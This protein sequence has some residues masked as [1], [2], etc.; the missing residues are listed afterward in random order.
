MSYIQNLPCESLQRIFELAARSGSAED[1]AKAGVIS[2][3][4]L[5]QVNRLF[6]TICLNTPSLWSTVSNRQP[7]HVLRL[8]IERSKAHPLCV[9]FLLYLKDEY[10]VFLKTLKRHAS[11]WGEFYF[12]SDMQYDTF[13]LLYHELRVIRRDLDLPQL[14]KLT[15]IYPRPNHLSRMDYPIEV[16]H[17]VHTYRPEHAS[18]QFY[19]SW[20]TPNLLSVSASNVFP[21]HTEGA[22]LESYA[23]QLTGSTR[24]WNC[25]P[26]L[27]VLPYWSKL[28]HLTLVFNGEEGIDMGAPTASMDTITTLLNLETLSMKFSDKEIEAFNHP[29][30]NR[31]EFPNVAEVAIYII[32]PD[33]MLSN[34][35]EPERDVRNQVCCPLRERSQYPNLSRFSL[36][37]R[38]DYRD[39]FSVLFDRRDATPSVKLVL[40][41]KIDSRHRE[42]YE[43][44]FRDR[45]KYENSL[46]DAANALT[47][48]CMEKLHPVFLRQAG[49]QDLTKMTVATE[50]EDQF[51]FIEDTFHDWDIQ[52]HPISL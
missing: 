12:E 50:S 20:K 1:A 5:A 46:I 11:R 36:K 47:I 14:R 43:A 28:R 23:V 16:M 29:V 9:V 8:C 42:G 30:L 25:V 21:Y 51:A 41:E 2:T 31:L 26:L 6:H 44:Q 10:A 52:R 3:F 24:E 19:Q 49:W 18:H 22:Q 40:N 7:A 35:V 13:L 48:A 27:A 15:L 34:S 4:N 17:W 37:Y 38:K 45:R 39:I 33:A 32:I